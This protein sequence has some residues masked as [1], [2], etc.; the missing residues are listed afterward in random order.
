MKI[1]SIIT[2]IAASTLSFAFTACDSKQENARENQ[3][4]KKA[5][6]MDNHADQ[7][8]KAAEAKANS[9]ENTADAI[10]KDAKQAADA[11]KNDAD[12]TRK[13]GEKKADAIENAADDVRK[14]K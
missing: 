10:K 11:T 6:A 7:V 3:L 2:L 12:A 13:A 9:K 4:E 5:D 14:Q 8:R 1:N